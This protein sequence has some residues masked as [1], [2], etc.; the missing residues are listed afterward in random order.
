MSR[1][2]LQE[3][4]R[5][6]TGA[7]PMIPDLETYRSANNLVKRHGEEAP[8]HAAKQAAA[9]LEAGDLEGYAMW[10]RILRAVEEL[11]GTEPRPG[12]AIH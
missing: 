9:M 8:I 7:A 10:E 6:E 11:Q 12:E 3:L 1:N 4:F 5:Y 2:E